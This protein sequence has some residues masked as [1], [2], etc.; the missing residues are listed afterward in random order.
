MRDPSD[1][2]PKFV[3]IPIGAFANEKRLGDELHYRAFDS[4]CVPAFVDDERPTLP[5]IGDAGDRGL[6]R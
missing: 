3:E 5:N 4:G 2:D 1:S 6:R